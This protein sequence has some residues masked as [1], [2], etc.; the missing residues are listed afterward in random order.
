MQRKFIAPLTTT[1]PTT[2]LGFNLT[3]ND[4][5]NGTSTTVPV[6]VND[7]NIVPTALPSAPKIVTAGTTVVLQGAS[8]DQI[9]PDVAPSGTSGRQYSWSQTGGPATTLT[10]GAG[11]GFRMASFTPAVAGTYTFQLVV[12][13][14]GGTG[15]ASRRRR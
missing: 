15:A 11:A 12:T 1:L 8:N 13:D 9:Q 7:N 2:T 4:T 14:H 6:T 10:P 5:T 3:V